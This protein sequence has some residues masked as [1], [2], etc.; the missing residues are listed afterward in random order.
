MSHGKSGENEGSVWVCNECGARLSRDQVAPLIL[1]LTLAV[2]L[3]QHQRCVELR[4]ASVCANVVPRAYRDL[5]SPPNFG[6]IVELDGA[7]ATV[8]YDS[9]VVTHGDFER[10]RHAGG[11][12]AP[13]GG[14]A[15]RRPDALHLGV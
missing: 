3:Q 8:E 6:S 12:A 11:P 15:C 14:A 5:G 4:Q 13:T 1:Q 10:T 2:F 9:D 7:V